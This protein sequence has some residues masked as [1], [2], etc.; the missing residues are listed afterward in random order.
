MNDNDLL[1][2]KRMII[3]HISETI[4]SLDGAGYLIQEMQ[5]NKSYGKLTGLRMDLLRQ[6]KFLKIVYGYIKEN[7]PDKTTWLY[8]TNV[9]LASHSL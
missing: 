8:H 4:G 3:N 6:K 2:E 7:Y 9:T 5:K 1:N